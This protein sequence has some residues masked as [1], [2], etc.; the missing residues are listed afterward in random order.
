MPRLWRAHDA[1]HSRLLMPNG[2]R[3]A[4][5]VDPAHQ[6]QSPHLRMDAVTRRA[7]VMWPSSLAPPGIAFEM[8]MPMLGQRGDKAERV[9]VVNEDDYRRLIE[10]PQR[11]RK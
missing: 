2:T 9:L 7:A 8:D 10:A 5:C 3:Q 1:P 4:C 11:R 6:P